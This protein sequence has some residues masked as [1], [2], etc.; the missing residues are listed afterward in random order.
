MEDPRPVLT[1]VVERFVNVWPSQVC[2]PG[3]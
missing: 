3:S 2:P 1:L